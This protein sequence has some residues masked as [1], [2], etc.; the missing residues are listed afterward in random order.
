MTQGPPLP[1][2]DY[3][4]PPQRRRIKPPE[5]EQ[6]QRWR[7]WRIAYR[8]WLFAACASVAFYFGPNWIKFHKLT[9]L[10]PYDYVPFVKAYGIPVV[11]AIKQYQRD[12]GR[13]PRDVDEL[14]PKYLPTHTATRGGW[15]NH[16]R[17]SLYSYYNEFVEYDF[18]PG[19]EGWSVHG[20]FANG[21]IP[22]TPATVEIDNHPTSQP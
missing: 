12:T 4:T 7:G 21:P 5:D 10:S 6:E 3:R 14:R 17:L 16:G 18:T 2:L 22:I 13:L 1:S 15:V 20:A 19:N 9:N 8:V 11:R